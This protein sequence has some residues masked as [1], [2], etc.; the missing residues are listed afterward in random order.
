MRPVLEGLDN[1]G[2]LDAIFSA[3]LFFKEKSP[4][5]NVTSAS[6]AFNLT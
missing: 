1:S 4:V 6:Q 2:I 3:C 5:I